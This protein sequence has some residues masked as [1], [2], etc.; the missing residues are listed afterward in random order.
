MSDDPKVEYRIVIH[1]M[2]DDEWE[3]QELILGREWTDSNQAQQHM[4]E[5][6]LSRYP[7]GTYALIEYRTMPRWQVW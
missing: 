5:M 3:E 4:S 1:V 6:D 2:E 7:K